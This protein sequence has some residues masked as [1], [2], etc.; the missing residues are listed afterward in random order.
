MGL[1]CRR[2]LRFRPIAHPFAVDLSSTGGY[3]RSVERTYATP[4]DA[5]RGDIPKRYARALSVEVSPDGHEALVVL[6]TNEEPYIEPYEVVCYREGERWVGGSGS[7][8][9]GFGWTSTSIGEDGE[10]LGVLR[11]A[12]EVPRDVEAVIVRWLDEEYR[13]PVSG[14]YFFF[15]RW[16]V[17][18]NSDE[19]ADPPKAVRYVGSDGSETEVPVDPHREHAWEWLRRR[20][21]EGE[22]GERTE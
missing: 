15:T 3:G 6:A 22:A 4:E 8:G 13:V 20:A 17:P 9:I 12:D 19:V 2:Q 16:N 1:R 10:N 18:D 14:G 21:G 11:L 5:A 7:G